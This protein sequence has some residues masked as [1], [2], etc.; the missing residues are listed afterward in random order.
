MRERDFSKSALRVFL[1]YYRPHA[2]LFALDLFMAL[3]G[4]GAELVFPYATRSAIQTLLPAQR[5]R[6]FFTVMAILLG[7]YILR[8][9]P[10][11]QAHEP[12]DHRPL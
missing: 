9:P 10:D 2:R 5:Y 7:A 12:D 1:S 6:A 11:R 3:V 8:H 4:V